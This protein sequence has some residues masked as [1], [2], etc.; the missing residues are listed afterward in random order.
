MA[1]R[2]RY[3]DRLAPPRPRSRIRPPRSAA[4]NAAARSWL[5]LIAV[6]W[7]AE[8][9][10]LEAQIR[11]VLPTTG[12][13]VR[14]LWLAGIASEAARKAKVNKRTVQRWKK[15]PNFAARLQN[16]TRI[17]LGHLPEPDAPAPSGDLLA[18][19]AEDGTLLYV[20]PSLTR[21]LGYDPDDV[22]GITSPEVM[23]PDDL[24]MV[25]DAF[26]TARSDKRADVQF[27]A[28]VFMDEA[29]VARGRVDQVDPSSRR[30][31]LSVWAEVDR[32]GERQ[33]PVKNSRAE[34]ELS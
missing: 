32:A 34:V 21:I 29:F 24:Q 30:V 28:P 20:T 2:T 14:E 26:T 13:A 7:T 19:C 17:T 18:V 4:G 22:I 11:Q 6:Y 3:E 31:T 12:V 27:R 16:V 25:I 15:D 1:A 10:K 5:G 33:L 9:A 23:H 8:V